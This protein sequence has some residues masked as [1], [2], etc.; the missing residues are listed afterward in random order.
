M[1]I[2]GL[3][4]IVHTLRLPSTGAA[5]VLH[6]YKIDA[7]IIYIDADHDYED[8]L[9]DLRLYYEL[10]KTGGIIFGDDYVDGWY[11]KRKEAIGV[12]QF[13]K[14]MKTIGKHLVQKREF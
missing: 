9:R 12:F 3:E 14:R 7:D 5:H 13:F 1:H 8:I 10:L 6:C 11:G 4:E 2:E